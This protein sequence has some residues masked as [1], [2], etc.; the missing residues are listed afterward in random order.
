LEAV[1]SNAVRINNSVTSDFEQ[2]SISPSF[3]LFAL[4][5]FIDLIRISEIDAVG[6]THIVRTRGQKPL[7]DPVMAEV[8]LQRFLPFLIKAN[9]IVGT[10][11][12][13]GFTPGAFVVIEYYNP[14]LSFGDRFLRTGFSAWGVVTVQAYIGMEDEIELPLNQLGPVLSHM[15]EFDLVVVFLFT[16]HFTSPAPPTEFMIY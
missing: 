9:G 6:K 16:G 10:F 7:I 4:H 5:N 12:D 14:V 2:Q 8:A 15:D 1:R 13:A 11:F 3:F